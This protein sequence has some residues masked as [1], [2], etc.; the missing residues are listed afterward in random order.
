MAIRDVTKGAT[1]GFSKELSEKVS[2]AAGRVADK[3]AEKIETHFL[4]I[5]PQDEARYKLAFDKIKGVNN[6][7]TNYLKGVVRDFLNELTSGQ[8]N[9][10]RRVIA[11]MKTK[12][13]AN[14]LTNF[15][16]LVDDKIRMQEAM[17]CGLVKMDLPSE[18]ISGLEQVRDELGRFFKDDIARL[19]EGGE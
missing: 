16:Y 9:W 19:E 4:G 8:K 1:E 3:G 5:G 2:K 11:E 14:S 12:D 15:A 7:Q 6:K 10:F 18:F 13:G 17:S